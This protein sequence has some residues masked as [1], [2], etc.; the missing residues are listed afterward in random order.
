MRKSLLV[1]IVFLFGLFIIPKGLSAATQTSE[2]SIL[3]ITSYNPDAGSIR[4]NILDFDDEY[5]ALGGTATVYVESMNCKSFFQAPTWRESL[6]DI[7]DKYKGDKKPSLIVLW[8]QEAWASFISV[9]D[10]ELSQVPVICGL[11]SRNAIILE[12]SSIPLDQ[13]SLESVDVVDD[14]GD[15]RIVGGYMTAYDIRKNIETALHLF[16]QTKNIVFLSDNTY[17]GVSLQSYVKKEM[18]NYPHLN[19]ILLDGRELSIYNIADH[20]K[21]LPNNSVML[22]GTWKV[23]TNEGY[24]MS[25]AITQMREANPDLPVFSVSSL[26][27]GVWAIGG[28]VP[29]Y[30]EIGKD[31]ARQASN[32]FIDKTTTKV[33]ELP[34]VYRFDKKQLDYFGISR[35]NLPADSQLLNVNETFWEQYK[36]EISIIMAAFMLLSIAFVISLLFFFRTKRMKDQLTKSESELREAKEKAEESNRLKSSF[37]ANMS[38]EI[39]T[40]LNA[41]VGFSNLLA[42]GGFEPEDQKEFATLIQ[43]N[44]DLLLNLINDILDVSRLETGK[45]KMIIEEIK[46]ADLCNQVLSTAAINRKFPDVEFLFK[47]DYP[48]FWLKTDPQRLSQVLIN[49]LSNANKFTRQGSITLEFELDEKREWVTFSVTDTGS[50]IPKDKIPVIFDRFEKLNEHVQGSGIGLSIC[51]LTTEKLGGKIWI[52]AKYDKGARF[53]FTHPTNLEIT[54]MPKNI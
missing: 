27:L 53:V 22:L 24:F 46:L 45:I 28:Y 19:L 48:D 26:G 33:E 36:V 1:I 39:R 34:N 44:S 30:R 37:L 9:R 11:V 50:G 17:G 10:H 12:D 51:K 40:P 2:Q 32:Y 13:W 35:G 42:D 5:K 21:Q 25:T 4:Q 41:I 14:C 43:N 52:D 16:P 29:Q 49:L 18:T 15:C 47:T 3:M 6:V 38:H 31:L 8:G 54:D 20:I 7:L 23:D